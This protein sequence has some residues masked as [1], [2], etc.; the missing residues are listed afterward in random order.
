MARARNLLGDSRLAD[1]I[2]IQAQF[3]FAAD[4]SFKAAALQTIATAKLYG[5]QAERA[6]TQAF[7]ERGFLDA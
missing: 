3:G 6:F 7:T 1:R 5:R 2:I 4:T